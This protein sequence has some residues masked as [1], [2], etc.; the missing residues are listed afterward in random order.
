MQ[1]ALHPLE[2]TGVPSPHLEETHTLPCRPP[3]SGRALGDHP[4][5][6]SRRQPHAQRRDPTKGARITVGASERLPHSRDLFSITKG[7][8]RGWRL[9]ET[10]VGLARRRASTVGAR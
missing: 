7:A 9:R 4:G 2:A 10:R 6:P 5:P 8:Q 1:L 3:G